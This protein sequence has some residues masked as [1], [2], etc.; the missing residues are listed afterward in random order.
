MAYAKIEITGTIKVVTGMHIGTNNS[1][2]AIGAI[3]SPVIRDTLTMLP[4]IPGSSIKGKM[5]YLLSRK[6]NDG[7]FS[8]SHDEDPKEVRRLFGSSEK[9]NEGR[10][11]KSRLIFHDAI[12]SNNDELISMG[13]SLATEVKVENSIKRMTAVANPRQIERVIAGAEFPLY[14]IYELTDENAPEDFQLIKEGFDLLQ[15]D[16]L[17]GHGSRG[18]GR[19]RIEDLDLNVVIGEIDEDLEEQCRDC[20]GV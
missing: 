5:R 19:I 16:Y 3:D 9:D 17:G 15:Y 4:M 10:I 12:I 11:H 14:I 2:S 1:Y 13:V 18:Y 8:K 6:Y 7:F 20:L